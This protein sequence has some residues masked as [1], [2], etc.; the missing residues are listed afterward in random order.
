MRITEEMGNLQ[1]KIFIW[2]KCFTLPLKEVGSNCVGPLPNAFMSAIE[3][4]CLYKSID[5]ASVFLCLVLTEMIPVFIVL[6]DIFALIIQSTHYS[7][8]QGFY[9]REKG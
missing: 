8:S 3:L 4:L 1:S 9:I 5:Y 2:L 6:K 7:S